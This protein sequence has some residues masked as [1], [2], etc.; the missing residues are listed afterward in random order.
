[1]A[2]TAERGSGVDLSGHGLQP[3]G[4]IYRN[5][6]TATLY[7][8]ALERNEAVLAEGGPLVVDTGAH[9]GRSP[10]DK[11]V[12]REPGSEG[13][14]WWGDVNSG[15]A[16]TRFLGLR[17]KVVAHL[18]HAESI[19]VIDSF[20]GADPGHRIGVRVVTELPAHALFAKT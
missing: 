2:T 11:F 14:I 9:T 7:T 16:E 6:T 19:Y 10:N 15:L 8:H 4:E 3:T 13:R 20:A 5:P 18:E 1:M 17:E 12:V